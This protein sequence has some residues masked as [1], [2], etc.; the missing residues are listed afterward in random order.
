[1]TSRG[2]NDFKQFV[3]GS[4]SGAM[5]TILLYPL[6]LIRTRMQVN[7]TV[8]KSWVTPFCNTIKEIYTERGIKT[9]YQGITPS[10]IG[11][12]A[13]WGCYFTFYENAKTRYRKISH[14]ENLNTFYNFLSATEAGIIGSVIT[15]PIWVIK[16]R[17]Q[18]QQKNL[19]PKEQQYKSFLDALI[20]IVQKE[21]FKTL[22]C[23]LI[24]SLLLVSHGVLQLTTYEECKRIGHHFNITDNGKTGFIYGGIS[25]AVASFLT[26]P[27]QVTRSRLQQFGAQSIYSGFINCLKTSFLKEGI[28]GLYSGF[29][30]NILRTVPNSS[31]TFM[32]Y[33]FMVNLYDKMSS[34]KN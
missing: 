4:T 5:P 34:I 28:R 2:R 10:L 31:I 7:N 33:E 16:T 14:T 17:M 15:A 9:F 23:G 8:Y 13:S 11:S 12:V 27:L 20:Q 6:D 3:C 21:G 22:Y 26:Y 29:I 24:P 30:P 32:T 25:K 19:I 18:L 1:M